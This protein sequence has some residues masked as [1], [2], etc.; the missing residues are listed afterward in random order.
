MKKKPEPP[1]DL[2]NQLDAY[3]AQT[4]NQSLIERP[5]NSKTLP[6]LMERWQATEH[7]AR[8]RIEKLIAAKKLKEIGWWNRH[9]VYLPIE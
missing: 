9:K 5:A 7:V 4:Y 1:A 8:W 3:I 2:W 6:E